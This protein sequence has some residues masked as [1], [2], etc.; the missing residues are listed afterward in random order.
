M[1]FTPD[2]GSGVAGPRSLTKTERQGRIVNENETNRVEPTRRDLLLVIGQLQK[3][4]GEAKSANNDRNPDRMAQVTAILYAAQ[5][6]CIEARGFE[7]PLDNGR[8]S[9]RGWSDYR[10]LAE[11]KAVK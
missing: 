11:I 1:I 5:S 2:S 10:T 3:L 9:A 7:P 6:L 4:V 8:R